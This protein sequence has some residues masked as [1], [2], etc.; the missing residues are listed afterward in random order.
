MS[1]ISWI[2]REKTCSAR[3]IDVLADLAQ[4]LRVPPAVLGLAPDQ[5]RILDPVDRRDVL[6][7]AVALAVS[8]LLPQGV[9]TAGR[10]DMAQV[11]QC[12]T[13]LNRLFEL[14]G[15]HGGGP[16]YELAAGMARRLQDA[17]ARGSYSPSVGEELHS[18]TAAAMEHA[19]WSAYDAGWQQRARQGWLETCHHADLADAPG[20]RVTALASMALQAERPGNGPEVVALAQAARTSAKDQATPTLLSL[21]AAREAIGHALH[22]DRAAAVSSVAEAR[23][24]LDHG[25]AGDEPF[26]LDF[27]G[28]ADL[29]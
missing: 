29:A 6:G 23:R 1:I 28:P 16:V 25:R 4:V 20:A 17:L 24:W 8:A 19:A 13:A 22:G 21:L 11:E 9:A 12:W 5:R 2:E 18:V 27:W 15:L 3:D 26:W 14:D 7:G 10:I